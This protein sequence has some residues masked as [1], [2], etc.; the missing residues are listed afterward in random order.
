MA[1]PS[2]DLVVLAVQRG[3]EDLRGADST[4]QAGDTLL[5]SGPWE[6]LERNTA[7]DDVLVVDRP[8]EVRRS[9]PLGV[10][11]KRAIGVLA[12]MVLL[13][14]TGIVP[15]AIAGLL[16]ASTLVLAR[17]V[18]PTQAYRSVSW[19][20]VLLVGGMIP[21]STAF[22]E[23]GTADLIAGGLLELIGDA[24]PYAALLAMCVLTVVLGQLISN[25]ATVLI[26]APIAVVVAADLSRPELLA[27]RVSLET[28]R[29][30]ESAD[31]VVVTA[32]GG[33]HGLP[34][35]GTM[36]VASEGP[37]TA[38]NVRTVRV[39]GTGRAFDSSSGEFIT[40][41]DLLTTQGAHAEDPA[42]TYAMRQW[43]VDRQKPLTWQEIERLN[44]YGVVA[45]SRH[46]ALHPETATRQLER[47]PRDEVALLVVGG[48]AL[49]LL[50]LT[51]L[52]AG[53]AFAVSAARQRHTL[54]LA[55]SNGATRA[56]LRR[57]VLGQALVLGVLSSL[58]G[59]GLG[60]VSGLG[61]TAVV[62][63][64]RPD[65][66]FGPVDIPWPAVGLVAIAAVVSSV[67]AALIPSRG[68]GR[69]DIVSVLRGQSVC[70]PLRPRVPVTGAVLT[71]LGAATLTWTSFGQAPLLFRVFL[72]GCVVLVVGAL[73]LVPLCLATVGK[74]AHRLPVPL[75]LAAR[76]AGRQ[77]GRATPT[78]AA[79]MAGAA[80]LAVV[81][82][83]LQADT[84]RKARDHTQVVLPGQGMVEWAMAQ[85]APGMAETLERAD[86]AVSTVT[87]HRLSDYDSSTP[88]TLLAA[89]RPGC[90]VE[91]TTARDDMMP[92]TGGPG[93]YAMCLTL[94]TDSPLADSS[95]AAAS[96]DELDRFLELTPAQRSALGAGAV[97]VVD[98]ETVSK[99][100]KPSFDSGPV[101]TIDRHR[102]VDVDVHDGRVTF[103]S[104]VERR[105][106]GD[107]PISPS[108]ADITLVDLPI[109][110]L[111]HEQWVRLVAGGQGG[112]GGLVTTDTALR[113]GATLRTDSL[114]VRAPGGISP[115]LES[116]LNDVLRSMSSDTFLVVE[117]GFQRDD[118]LALAILF[119]VI[120]L[121]ILVATLIATAL[122]QAENTPLLG[123]LAAVGATRA[124]RRAL[125]GAQ[126]LYLGLLGSVLGLGIGLVPG[127]A[128]ARLLTTTYT[129]DGTP[130]LPTSVDIP[131]PQV[132]LPLLAVPVVAG[133]LA[134][135]S[136]RR[137]P[138][139]TRR[140]T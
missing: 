56:Q 15:P 134:W 112:P 53:P 5:L 70:A 140:T 37:G 133:A 63:V 71:A 87:L 113:L 117:R 115:E 92:V 118:P 40:Q 74:V 124:T 28:G 95:L 90:T 14:A 21:L 85:P 29:W 88:S 30:P 116:S 22:V 76:E 107:M 77:R 44:T 49:G 39:V 50:L 127:V 125:A 84:V 86:P 38:R 59:S 138:T 20:T 55:A 120:G 45:Y 104:Y 4:L 36:S 51:T 65:L 126:A 80:V 23:T 111:T 108:R 82:V 97:G 93:T 81:A 62:R 46:V 10:G 41:A 9:V 132:A 114:L 58:V 11:A 34:S 96:L 75:R 61:L 7:G 69:L 47:G 2:G 73:M 64:V 101:Q 103:A 31:E 68:L 19:T 72:A 136:I 12:V 89:Q 137:A 135:L 8:S 67:V 78:V 119:G 91:Q 48:S 52:L 27:P 1:T 24:S 131:W 100:P 13:L 121:V 128:I 3:G 99:L 109:V 139:V 123:T 130:V 26:V 42:A 57:S 98:P 129:E 32:Q 106:P 33:E 16:A 83:A 60:L 122:S 17:V 66:L 94:A 54:A 6:L 25:T 102:P 105:G 79:I 110:L 18:T 43:L 35:S